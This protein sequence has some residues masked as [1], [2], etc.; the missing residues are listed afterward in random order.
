MHRISGIHRNLTP[1]LSGIATVITP[2]SLAGCAGPFSTL[3]PAGPSAAGSAGLWWW[4]FTLAML[5]LLAVVGLWLGAMFGAQKTGDDQQLRRIQQRWI[6]GGGLLLPWAA[7]AVLLAF[8]IPIGHKMLPLPLEGGEILRIDV[9]GHQWW[10]QV[11]YPGSGI[12][13]RNEVHIPVGVPVDLHLTSADVVH[14]FWV[15]RLGGKLDM[16]PGRTNV[17]RL[18]A[19]IADTYRGQCAEFCGLN[20]A[21]MQFTVT[22]HAP[23]D[24]AAWLTEASASD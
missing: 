14:S 24:F 16:I 1:R 13:L 2:L 17:L 19:D 6:I 22:A 12:Q 21:H 7:I 10:W 20:H 9:T 15:P 18:Q 4:M 3:D 23:G 8:G 5:V 11:S